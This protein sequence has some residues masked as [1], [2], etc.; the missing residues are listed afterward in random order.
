MANNIIPQ[1]N[2]GVL[3][4]QTTQVSY[5]GPL[6]QA[7]EFE[8]YNRVLPGAAD[9]ILKM[10]EEQAKHRQLMEKKV[11]STGQIKS[12]IGLVFAFIIATVVLIGSVF[13]IYTGKSWQG[14][15]GVLIGLA[16]IVGP[17]IYSAKQQ[18]EQLK[19]N[20]KMLENK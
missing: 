9:R 20:K 10:A 5:S 13:L 11:I 8:Y 1:K 19:E 7:S 18:K 2:G 4:H 15:S 14:L 6:P 3:A 12:I 17:F 16:A